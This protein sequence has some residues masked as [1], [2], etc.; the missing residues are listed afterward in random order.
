MYRISTFLL[1]VMLMHLQVVF[2]QA[3]DVLWLKDY[4]HG[5]LGSNGNSLD[6]TFDGGSILAGTVSFGAGSS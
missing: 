3:P 4:G 6:T 2:A 1:F 5:I